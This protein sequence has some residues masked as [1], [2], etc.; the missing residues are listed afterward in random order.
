MHKLP[1]VPAVVVALCVGFASCLNSQLAA[2][3]PASPST[4]HPL[5]RGQQTAPPA[6][7]GAPSV[8]QPSATIQQPS[9]GA[10]T[11]KMVTIVFQKALT[12]DTTFVSTGLGTSA[13]IY[14]FKRNDGKPYRLSIDWLINE[15]PQAVREQIFACS[16]YSAC[17]RFEVNGVVQA[18]EITHLTVTVRTTFEVAPSQWPLSIRLKMRARRPGEHGQPTEWP[19]TSALIHISANSYDY[20]EANL[21]PTFKHPRCTTCHHMGDSA[22]I[23]E[24][25][26]KYTVAGGLSGLKPDDASSGCS[27]CHQDIRQAETSGGGKAKFLGQLGT[28]TDF[29]WKSPAFSKNINWEKKKDARDVCTTVVA[30]LPTKEALHKHFHNDARLAWAVTAAD[31]QFPASGGSPQ[32]KDSAPPGDYAKFLAIVDKWL[33]IG[34]PCKP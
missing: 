34:F 27:N 5:P 28:F 10:P 19:Y 1:A 7:A 13:S 4:P 18:P 11:F 16:P 8:Q 9:T 32:P 31:V 30:H 26:K 29:E 23:Y 21:Y 24:Q 25:H 22:A 20:F 33:A 15:I 17:Y 12:A 3:A 14:V 2:Q 6:R